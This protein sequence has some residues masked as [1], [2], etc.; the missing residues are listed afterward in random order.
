M[1]FPCHRLA[2]TFDDLFAR[3]AD[4][5][6]V[7]CDELVETDFFSKPEEARQV[8]WERSETTGVIPMAGGAHPSSCTP[9]Y[10]H[11]A[12]HFKAYAAS[13]KEENG[14]QNYVEQYVNCSEAEYIEKVGG[15]EAI[16]QLPLPI[17]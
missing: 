15:L 9:L 12:T 2:G 8:F 7:S 11:D 3:A 17:Y 6:F 14:W 16:K 13:A 1:V 10:G 5:T 4:K